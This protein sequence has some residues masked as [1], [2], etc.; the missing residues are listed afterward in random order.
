MFK[1]M[2]KFD[3]SFGVQHQ[4]YCS[5][6]HIEH[7][8]LAQTLCNISSPNLVNYLYGIKDMEKCMGFVLVRGFANQTSKD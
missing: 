2:D 6:S 3:V 4:N 7:V 1:S 8:K 5:K